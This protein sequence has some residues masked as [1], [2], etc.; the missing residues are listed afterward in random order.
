MNSPLDFFTFIHFFNF[1]ILSFILKNN[2]KIAFLIGI[3]WEIVEY[4]IANNKKTNKLLKHY[5]PVPEKYWN[6]KHNLNPVF[7]IL[8]N[9]LG[10][11]IGTVIR[12]RY[13]VNLF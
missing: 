12:N 9:M 2:Y 10:Y 11:Y 3:V 6:E 4:V 5:W 13:V 1:F 7:D 8:F